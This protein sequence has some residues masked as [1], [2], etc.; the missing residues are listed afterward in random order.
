MAKKKKRQKKTKGNTGKINGSACRRPSLPE[1]S[2]LLQRKEYKKL[3]GELE[4][5]DLSEGKGVYA[6]LKASCYLFAGDYERAFEAIA[7]ALSLDPGNIEFNL[8]YAHCLEKNNE[9]VKAMTVFNEIIKKDPEEKRA[10]WHLGLVLVLMGRYDGAIT[11]FKRLLSMGAKKSSCFIK[12][13]YC[14]HHLG[15]LDKAINYYEQAVELGEHLDVVWGEIA[16]IFKSKGDKDMARMAFKHAISAA[17]TNYSLY[18]SYVK[19]GGLSREDSE[20][21]IERLNTA[22]QTETLNLSDLRGVHFALATLNHDLKNYDAA[23]NHFELGNRYR[24]SLLGVTFDVDTFKDRIDYL[25]NNITRDFFSRQRGAGSFSRKP[26]FIVGMPRSGTTL[27]EQIIASHSSGGAAGE[28]YTIGQ[29][30][31]EVMGRNGRVLFERIDNLG[32][33]GIDAFAVRY[34]DHLQRIGGNAE[35]IVD[36]MPGNL[37]QVWFIALLFPEA[38]IIHCLRDP[39]DTC[40]SCFMHDF[41]RGHTYKKD[42][43]TLG[44]YYS[45]YTGLMD[46]WKKIVPN[47]ILTVEYEKVVRE[48]EEMARKIIAHV[49]L[50]WD[51]AC[52]K[53]KNK[54]HFSLTASN[55]QI[56]KGIYQ[57]SVQRWKPYEKHLGPL[58]RGMAEEK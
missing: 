29:L 37:I 8:T 3:L 7:L 6:N 42:L 15:Q 24:A 39:R 40:L 35:R 52:V 45:I 28:L 41:L 10:Y 33:E 14:H 31:T 48:P 21:I 44:R 25:R 19:S 56:R 34:L 2:G 11:C 30:A 43:Y 16:A 47:P 22:L 58:L 57:S 9:L 50:E 27:L 5:F 18:T 53:L 12:L 55:L 38:S 1:L 49:G 26:V 17:P 51:P 32:P 36:K 54:E 4:H 46:H 23:F 20:E 13:G